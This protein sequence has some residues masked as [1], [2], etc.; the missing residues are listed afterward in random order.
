MKASGNT[1]PLVGVDESERHRFV[2]W[3]SMYFLTVSSETCPTV[4]K[5]VPRDHNPDPQN[6]LAFNFG[7]ALKILTADTDFSVLATPTG[8]VR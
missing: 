6:L 7:N 2:F 8:A 1:T 5:Y 3:A 4:P